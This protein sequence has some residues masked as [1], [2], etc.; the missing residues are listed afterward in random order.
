[1]EDLKAQATEDAVDRLVALLMSTG[2]IAMSV[3]RR[4]SRARG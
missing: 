2:L 1:M 4:H 3:S